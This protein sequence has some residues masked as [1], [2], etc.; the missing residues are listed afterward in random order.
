MYRIIGMLLGTMLLATLPFATAAEMSDTDIARALMANHWC[1]F[2][3]NKTTGYSSR[4]VAQFL[5]NGVLTIGRNA[6][7]GVSG[8]AGSYYGQSQ[9]GQRYQWRVLGTNLL[10]APAGGAWEVYALDAYRTSAGKL[11]LKVAGEEWIAC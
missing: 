7:G 2:S 5:G 8:P 4:R 11:V 6:E 3:Y 9:G 1:N 10:L